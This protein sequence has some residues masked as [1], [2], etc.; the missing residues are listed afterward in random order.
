ALLVDEPAAGVTY[1]TTPASATTAFTDGDAEDA[2]TLSPMADGGTLLWRYAEEVVTPGVYYVSA[3]GSDSNAG[4]SSAAPLATLGRAYA[5]IREDM[6]AAGDLNDAGAVGTIVVV[7]TLPLTAS[8]PDFGEEHVYTVVVTGKNEGD[9][10]SLQTQYPYDLIGPTRFEDV[11]LTHNKTTPTTE[12][13]IR[14]MGY[15]LTIGEGVTTVAN[16]GN[17][18][19]IIGGKRA[20]GTYD[21][22]VS[23]ASGTWKEVVG[24]SRTGA[25]TGDVTVT[26][27]GGTVTGRVGATYNVTNTGT[28][29]IT[30]SDCTVGNVY[31]AAI[32]D[33]TSSANAVVSLTNVTVT[34]GVYGG[35]GKN[36]NLG[37]N[38]VV[39]IEGGSVADEV[40]MNF[41]VSKTGTLNLVNTSVDGVILLSNPY[42]SSDAGTATLNLD[43]SGAL[44]LTAGDA[45]SVASFTGGGALTL[46]QDTTLTVSSLTG[47]TSL[48]VSGGPVA[49]LAYV[50][51]LDA[52]APAVFTD[53][54]TSDAYDLSGEEE[55]GTIAWKFHAPV[56]LASTVYVSPSGSDENTGTANTRPLATLAKA[57]EKLHDYMES[58]GALNDPNAVGT[59]VVLGTLP[60]AVNNPSFGSEH[61]YKVVVTGD[62]P[63]DGFSLQVQYPYN[64][65]G[66]TTF[67]NIT[68]R[69][70]KDTSPTTEP[71][72]RGDG[73]PLTIGEGVT[74]VGN[75]STATTYYP[76]LFG[77]KTSTGTYDGSVS[78][79]SGTWDYVVGGSRGGTQTGSS[80]VTITGGEVKRAV[81]ATYNAANTGAVAITI[82]DAT[83]K[84]IYGGPNNTNTHTGNSVLT[85]TDAVV[86]GN[87]YAGGNT[88]RN[89]GGDV[90]LTV[91]GG[92]VAGEIVAN[93]KSTSVGTVNLVNTSVAGAVV[94]FN[95]RYTGG[96]VPGL[97][98]LNLDA[99]TALSLTG[100]GDYAAASFTGGGSLTLG[101]NSTLTASSLTGVTALTVSGGPAESWT[102]VEL[103]GSDNVSAFTDGDASD[104]LVPV[105]TIVGDDVVWT[106]EAAPAHP[107][108]TLASIDLGESISFRFYVPLTAQQLSQTIRADFDM[109]VVDETN[110]AQSV[111][112]ANAVYDSDTDA[113]VFT[114]TGVTPQCIDDDVTAELY[115][116]GVKVD[117]I[118]LSVADY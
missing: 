50:T 19:S 110:K 105:G 40:V 88:D 102:Y 2:F 83:V 101:Q 51:V 38:A 109:D 9:G 82:S 13:C 96:N 73:H 31:G 77:G 15:P 52:S 56:A 86:T 81:A 7:G 23:V 20:A 78:V 48:T 103:L 68:L 25:Q 5:L 42:R 89:T 54:N 6:A 21:S 8:A 37:G 29:T 45:L 26:M 55:A 49:G 114:Y 16:S 30:L 111:S 108:F 67:E 32:T 75:T 70:D 17:Y 66:P 107:A 92:S 60:L 72:I 12:P 22:S 27:T 46:G 3:A 33:T 61:A 71:G 100:E 24:G 116:D 14:A 64:I 84:D 80:A 62:T 44:S 98:T 28:N 1:V 85:I 95:D 34:G 97:A 76:V 57:Y 74:T 11:T 58:A 10:F 94:L 65:L 41:N 53:G 79:A 91:T 93:F 118:V 18:P 115:V 90:T 59:I 69:H 112:L 4:T 36:R 99:S 87:I 35:P 106:F 47:D 104:A 39:T 63:Q 43:A 113:Y 117:T